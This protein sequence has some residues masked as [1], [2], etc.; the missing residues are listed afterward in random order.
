M[1]LSLLIFSATDASNFSFRSFNDFVSCVFSDFNCSI[2][3]AT[4]TNKKKKKKHHAW[5]VFLN[6]NFWALKMNRPTA[7]SRPKYVCNK[8]L[9]ALF[10]CQNWL[11]RP[12]LG[13]IS[14][15]SR[16]RSLMIAG[17]FYWTA[18][19]NRAYTSP[20]KRRVP[21]LIKTIQPDQF[22]LE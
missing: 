18:A 4:Y 19:G 17:T 3:I 2:S 5:C 6:R 11:A 1:R 16:V 7:W 20:V 22:I 9:R 13:S 14:A 8:I 21:L 10:I 15:V 12:V